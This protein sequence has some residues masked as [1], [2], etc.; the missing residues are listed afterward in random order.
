MI[1]LGVIEESKSS[2]NN[3]VMMMTKANG[4][5]RFCL[6]AKR[7][8]EVTVKDVYGLPIIDGLLSRLSDTHNISAIDLRDAF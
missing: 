7:L 4:K 3:P 1:A 8:N 5:E 2:L 6:D